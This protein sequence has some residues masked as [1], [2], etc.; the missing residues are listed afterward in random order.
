MKIPDN[1]PKMVITSDRF[2]GNSFEGIKHM[3]IGD[4]LL[5]NEI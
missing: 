5:L 3:Y 2:N 4:F 1:Y